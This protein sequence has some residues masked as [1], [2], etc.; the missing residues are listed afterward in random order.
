[1]L[2]MAEVKK[3]ERSLLVKKREVFPSD[4]LSVYENE[5]LTLQ[6]KILGVEKVAM[7]KAHEDEVKVASLYQAS[8]DDP[9]LA[10]A[11]L[12]VLQEVGVAP[13]P[14]TQY[15]V[16]DPGLT[17]G[18]LNALNQ[19]IVGDSS[20]AC[21]GHA[22]L[23]EDL[24][25]TDHALLHQ[26]TDGNPS[27]ASAGHSILQEGL[28]ST[29][30][31]PIYQDSDVDLGLASAG[32]DAIYQTIDRDIFQE[33]DAAL[34]LVVTHHCDGDQDLA[35]AGNADLYQVWEYDTDLVSAGHDSFPQEDDEV[36]FEGYE[37]PVLGGVLVEL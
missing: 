8:D 19:S 14:V 12:D 5:M 35:T 10:T 20:L 18:G 25:V 23:Q 17:T 26:A 32:Q 31:A 27:L 21:D 4:S 37:I 22:V 1:M 15:C 24:D 9:G 33:D 3:H 30:H 6:L 29:A 7:D 2:L 13:L 36:Q 16:G 28:A 34:H 11:G